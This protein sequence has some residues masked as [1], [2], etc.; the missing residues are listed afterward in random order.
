MCGLLRGNQR[1]SRS[2]ALLRAAIVGLLPCIAACS[3][4]SP[5]PTST[6]TPCDLSSPL[7]YDNFG[8]S[9]MEKYC[10]RCHHSELRGSQRQGASLYHDFDTELGV[11]LVWEHVD[12]YAAAGPAS[13]NEMMP[14]DGDK[15]SLEER[16]QLGQWVACSEE[17][18]NSVSDAGVGDAASSADAMP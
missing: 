9:F 15:P 14:P 7:S 8:R 17:R 16:T 13:V 12:Q 2:L 1:V 4:A 11:I 10:T 18:Y 5:E 6:E 3:G